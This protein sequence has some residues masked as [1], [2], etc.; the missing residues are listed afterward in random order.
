MNAPRA[1]AVS[2]P[3]GPRAGTV[4]LDYDGRWRRRAALATDDGMRFLLDLPEASDLRDG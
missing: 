3:S 1:L 2:P 4:T